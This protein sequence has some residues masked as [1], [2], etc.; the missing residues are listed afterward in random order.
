MY[1]TQQSRQRYVK[2]IVVVIPF[3][4]SPCVYL[5]FKNH[6]TKGQRTEEAQGRGYM[7]K[8]KKWKDFSGGLVARPCAYTAKG[9]DLISGQGTTPHTMQQG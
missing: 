8:R 5:E 6:K 2:E 9:P 4:P 3:F 7:K 1:T